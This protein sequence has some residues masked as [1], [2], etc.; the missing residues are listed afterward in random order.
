LRDV[1]DADAEQGRD[2][3]AEQLGQFFQRLD[4]CKFALLEAVER[5]PRDAETVG[6]L[7]GA[8]SRAEAERLQPV[9][10]IVEADGHRSIRMIVANSDDPCDWQTTPRF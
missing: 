2:G 3:D 8:E 5:G 7:V 6:D 10:D 4:L 1:F 9:S